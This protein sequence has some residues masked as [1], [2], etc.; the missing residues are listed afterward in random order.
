MT[1]NERQ[2]LHVPAKLFFDA[3]DGIFELFNHYKF[4]VEENTPIEQEV[5]LDPELLGQVFENLLGV[6]NPET[7]TTSTQGYRLLLYTP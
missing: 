1:L 7:Q 3:V 5:A 2:A 6:Y 4:T